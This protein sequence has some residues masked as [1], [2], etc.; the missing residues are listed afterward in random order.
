[1]CILTPLISELQAV[2]NLG[3]WCISVQQ[4]AAPLLAAHFHSLLLAVVHAIDNPIGSLSTTFEAMQ[5]HSAV[6]CSV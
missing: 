2:C 4:L 1:M 3:V 6:I 5:V